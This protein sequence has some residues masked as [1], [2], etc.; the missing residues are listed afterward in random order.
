ME[1]SYDII[2]LIV[3]PHNIQ[4]VTDKDPLTILMFDIP[5]LKEPLMSKI[6]VMIKWQYRYKWKI[7]NVFFEHVSE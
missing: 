4:S 5:S 1:T 3:L 7:M 6:F 2:L